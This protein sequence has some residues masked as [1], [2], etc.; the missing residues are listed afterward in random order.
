MP[1]YPFHFSGQL[2]TYG[3][4]GT[5][6]YPFLYLPDD[7]VEALPEGTPKRFR[8]EIV[9]NGQRRVGSFTPSKEG[10]CMMLSKAY[11]AEAGLQPG[12]ECEVKMRILPQDHVEM[13][14]ILSTALEADTA[15]R[16]AWE[17]MTPGQ[18]RSQAH[19]IAS[20]KT[21]PTRQKR[22]E[23]VLRDLGVAGDL[24]RP[25]HLR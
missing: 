13:P 24:T 21:E 4:E 16:R 19:Q 22:L 11:L 14:E 6:R 1:R 23:Q 7:V 5:G 25:P 9:V 17:Q 18:R 2:Q 20:A 12:G 15:A 8:A 3:T 10:H